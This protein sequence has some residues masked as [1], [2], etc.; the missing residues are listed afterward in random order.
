MEI[1]DELK[2]KLQ[3]LQKQ[4]GK[5]Q[6]FEEAVASIRSLL[7][8]FYPSASPSLRKSV[9]STIMFSLFGSVVVIVCSCYLVYL[10]PELG[11]IQFT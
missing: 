8:Q 6:M 9:I 4:L 3:D 1:E 2:Q 10:F 5:K 7:H 11:K